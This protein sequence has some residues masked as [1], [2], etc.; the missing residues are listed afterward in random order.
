QRLR[1]RSAP[2]RPVDH[3]GVL[4][5]EGFGPPKSVNLGG[6]PRPRRLFLGALTPPCPHR[7]ITHVHTHTHVRAAQASASTDAWFVE[8]VLPLERRLVRYLAHARQPAADIDDLRQEVFAR[9]Y[10]APGQ[11]RPSPAWP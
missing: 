8:E 3:Q 2:D 9:V 6:G 11:H 10:E 4:T 7:P 5:C 1:P